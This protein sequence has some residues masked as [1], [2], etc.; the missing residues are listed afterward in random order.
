MLFVGWFGSNWDFVMEGFFLMSSA[1]AWNG[2]AICAPLKIG[3]KF[4]VFRHSFLIMSITMFISFLLSVLFDDTNVHILIFA[5]CGFLGGLLVNLMI[6]YKYK[7]TLS[8][9]NTVLLGGLVGFQCATL[10][11]YLMAAPSE[12]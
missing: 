7:H 10:R 12:T 2:L 4:N 11:R 1:V 6:R 3:D 9:V 5:A 8:M